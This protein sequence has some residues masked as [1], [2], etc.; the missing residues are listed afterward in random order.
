[1]KAKDIE[2]TPINY[3]LLKLITPQGIELKSSRVQMGEI[4][5]RIFYIS[6]FPSNVNLGWLSNLKDIIN[7]TISLVVNPIEDVQSYINGISKGMTTDKNTYNTSQN[8]ALR[9]QA[10]F[11]IKS[12]EKIIKDITVDN[13]PY[14][15]LGIYL[16]VSADTETA[17]NENVRAL[18]NKIAGMGL[19]GRIPA[20]IQEK[21]LKQCSPFD[22][23]YQELSQISNK[24]MSLKALFRRTSFF[25]I[26]TY[27]YRR[28]LFRN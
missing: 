11:K 9:T 14:I 26:W 3:D 18:K 22:T 6:G 28:L 24:D 27:R 2:R 4:Y 23:C 19:K 13:I 12:A 5:S 10:S 21:A 8:E 17:F 16:K 1:M 25:W 15:R 7:T 20:F